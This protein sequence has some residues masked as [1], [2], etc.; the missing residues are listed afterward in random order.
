MDGRSALHQVLADLQVPIDKHQ[1]VPVPRADLQDFVNDGTA[2]SQ[3]ATGNLF[4]RV[5]AMMSN[6]AKYNPKELAALEWRDKIEP[7]IR[8]DMNAQQVEERLV[9]AADNPQIKKL[10]TLWGLLGQRLLGH[11]GRIQVHRGEHGRVIRMAGLRGI[12]E[13]WQVPTLICDATGD[14]E[15]LR[16]IWPELRCDVEQWQQLPRPASVR[17]FQ[18]VDRAISKWAVAVEGEGVELARR[19]RA[20][21]RLYAAVLTKALEYDGREVAMVVYKSTE[22]WI[23][24]NCFVPD[25]L[26]IYHHGATEG[27]NELQHVRALFVIGRPL[28][29]PEAVVRMTEALFGEYIAQREYL[30]VRKGGRIPIVP[31]AAGNSAILVDIWRHPNSAGERMRRQ[32]TEAGL[33]QAVGRARAGLRGPGYPLDIHLWTD[34]AL[35]ELGPVEPVLW[36]EVAVGLDEMMMATAGVWLE[37]V[38]HAAKAYEG[39]FKARTLH[40]ARVRAQ[41]SYIPNNKI[42]ISNVATLEVVYQLVGAR[43]QISHAKSLLGLNET[44]VWLETKLGPLASFGLVTA[45]GKAAD[46]DEASGEAVG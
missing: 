9:D 33:I 25:W 23:R 1:G 14:A 16:A 13:G 35:P 4:D 43:Q 17:I 29:S 18:C 2:S 8:P 19:E 11:N 27:T 10:I 36:D 39:L 41:A 46:D 5:N 32:I 3:A 34:V 30:T 31:D 44:K 28:A 38:S 6:G 22:T 21:R 26:K 7:K 45:A 42:T 24:A 37:N 40:Q 12:A 20:A 15:L